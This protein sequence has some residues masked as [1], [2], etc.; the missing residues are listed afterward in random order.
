MKLLCTLLLLVYLTTCQA[1]SEDTVFRETVEVPL[2]AVVH[3]GVVSISQPAAVPKP[4]DVSQGLA[5]SQGK[6]CSEDFWRSV[7]ILKN[8]LEINWVS[9]WCSSLHIDVK[10]CDVYEE[11]RV[12]CWIGT[13]A[14]AGAVAFVGG[15]GIT[16]AVYGCGSNPDLCARLGNLGFQFLQSR[17]KP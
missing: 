15:Y 13:V 5:V 6:S 9:H 16:A 8:H 12:G 11:A 2:Q 17:Q 1:S 4:Q 14:T 3:R 7:D 10:T